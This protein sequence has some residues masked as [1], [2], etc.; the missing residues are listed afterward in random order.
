MHGEHAVLRQPLGLR[1]AF[2]HEPLSVPADASE[3]TALPADEKALR[4]LRGKLL[5]RRSHRVRA[6]LDCFLKSRPA[7]ESELAGERELC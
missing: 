4:E 6:G 1:E 3:A 5:A 7:G 2:G